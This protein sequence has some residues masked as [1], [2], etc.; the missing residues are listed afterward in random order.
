[1]A[2][3]ILH[4]PGPAWVIS[5]SPAQP[6]PQAQGCLP[7]FSHS[8]RPSVHIPKKEKYLRLQIACGLSIQ[9]PL[10]STPFPRESQACVL[11]GSRLIAQKHWTPKPSV[12]PPLPSSAGQLRSS[13]DCS[14]PPPRHFSF[15]EVSHC[16]SYSQKQGSTWNH[17][18]CPHPDSP[19]SARVPC[20][21]S[22]AA[23]TGR[24]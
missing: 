2:K 23:E 15:R 21:T 10:T 24:G 13:K 8:Q 5:A 16:H 3:S 20:T 12:L 11:P 14:Q 18:Q 22:C 19:A 17:P 1:M 9:Q 7:G 4:M 6:R